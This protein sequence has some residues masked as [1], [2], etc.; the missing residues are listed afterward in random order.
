MLY[1]IFPILM[2]SLGLYLIINEPKDSHQIMSISAGFHPSYELEVFNIVN[3]YRNKS[4]MCGNTNYPRTFPLILNQNLVNASRLHSVD[5]SSKN[6]FSHTSLDG[7]TFVTRIKNA[8]YYPYRVIG[9][10]I[11]AGYQT[12]TTMMT[13]LM[14]SPGHC[15]NIMSSSYKE[16]GV[17]YSFNSGSTYKYYWTQDFGSRY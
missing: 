5:M 15:S 16:L 6:Y 2:L 7:R 9:E 14:S 13:A 1:T 4:V 10:N 3:K 17:G 12:P 8:G 11:A